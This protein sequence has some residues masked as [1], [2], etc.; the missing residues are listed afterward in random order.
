MIVLNLAA[1][2]VGIRVTFIRHAAGGTRH[3]HSFV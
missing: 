3:P 1:F 2:G